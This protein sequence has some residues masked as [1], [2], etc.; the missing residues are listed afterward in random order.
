LPADAGGCD[1]AA[2]ALW[3]EARHHRIIFR[4]DERSLAVEVLHIRHGARKPIKAAG[5]KA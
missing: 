5:P 3:D 1:A 4:V 2:S